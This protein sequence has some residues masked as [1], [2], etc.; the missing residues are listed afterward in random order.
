MS[1]IPI[2]EADIIHTL[3]DDLAAI[4]GNVIAAYAR[5]E[6]NLTTLSAMLLQLNKAEARL[7]LRTPR[8]T[9]RLDMALDLFAIKALVP[10]GDMAALRTLI[11]EASA[12]RD[13]IAHGMWLRHP[14]DG[15]IFLRMARGSWPKAMTE[16]HRISRTVFPQ[17]IPYGVKDCAETLE[18]VEL[19]L[20]R[21]DLLGAQIDNLIATWPDRFGTPAP[22]LNPLGHRKPIA[23]QAPRGSSRRKR[24]K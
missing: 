19:A 10:V 16:G 2:V 15:Q 1:D 17:S 3:P 6:Y 13:A 8:A 12:G 20:R 9:D 11:E 22:N 18:K 14:E 7:A 4:I 5:L 24:E 21:L 23:A